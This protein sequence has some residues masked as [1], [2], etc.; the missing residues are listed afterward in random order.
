M[1]KQHWY[2]RNCR[3]LTL[4]PYLGDAKKW[5]VRI[6][7]LVISRTYHLPHSGCLRGTE[8]PCH[9][10]TPAFVPVGSNTRQVTC[11]SRSQAHTVAKS[12]THTHTHTYTQKQTHKYTWTP[13]KVL[14]VIIIILTFAASQMD[15]VAFGGRQ[16]QRQINFSPI[17]RSLFFANSCS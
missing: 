12:K 6:C 4:E 17:F 2:S 16:S 8:A 9:I 7:A 14:S 3:Y 5:C 10:V 15:S 1:F 11:S 13:T